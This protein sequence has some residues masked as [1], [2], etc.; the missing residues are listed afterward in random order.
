MFE[1]AED[2]DGLSS[3]IAVEVIA[4]T[5][6]IEEDDTSSTFRATDLDVTE[7]DDGLYAL[8]HVSNYQ[9]INRHKIIGIKPILEKKIE[10]VDPTRADHPRFA[11]KIGINKRIT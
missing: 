6:I 10:G 7:D 3:Q 9:G 2:D 5:H 4:T 8:A 1:V 11:I